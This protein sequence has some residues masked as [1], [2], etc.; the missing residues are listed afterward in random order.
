M[1]SI[2][3]LPEEAVPDWPQANDDPGVNRWLARFGL[4]YDEVPITD[5]PPVGWHFILGLSP[6]GGQHAVVGYNG[7]FVHDPHPEADDPRRGLRRP[8]H[9]GVLSR[10]KR[11]ARDSF[12]YDK[13]TMAQLLDAM[14]LT[15]REYMA[16]SEQRK[17]ALLRAAARELERA[18]AKDSKPGSLAALVLAY[19]LGRYLKGRRERK[20]RAMGLDGVLSGGAL[21]AALRPV[22]RRHDELAAF[23]GADSRGAYQ[24]RAAEVQALVAETAELLRGTRIS[25][26]AVWTAHAEKATAAVRMARQFAQSGEWGCALAAQE[27][28]VTASH[29]VLDAMRGLARRTGA[30]DVAKID[31]DRLAQELVRIHN[32]AAKE[33]KAAFAAVGARMWPMDN[34][35][36]YKANNTQ[37]IAN[38]MRNGSAYFEHLP[39]PLTVLDSYPNVTQKQRKW[40]RGEVGK[41]HAKY[42]TEWNS[43]RRTGAKDTTPPYRP[44]DTITLRNGRKARVVKCTPAE[45][46][47]HEPEWHVLTDTGD[48]LVVKEK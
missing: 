37:A 20:R 27:Y 18:Q 12:N 29:H 9:W 39:F 6:R 38:S 8:T 1:A 10:A 44:G 31:A 26:K 35:H 3:E 30:K 32:A 19:L 48:A 17:E 40:L 2:L 45:N 16:S 41:I 21:M 22:R 36:L 4:R 11:E 33:Y 42:Q 34:C 23:S 25:D 13:W 15:I 14:G 24:A 43:V 5:P 47:F 28:A 7:K 46:L